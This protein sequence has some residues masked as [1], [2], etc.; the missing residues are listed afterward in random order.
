MSSSDFSIDC[1]CGAQLPVSAS[2]AGTTLECRCGRT[3]KVPL[4]SELRKLQGKGAYESGPIETILR[5]T[6]EGRL[7]SSDVCV[8]SGRPTNDI[9]RFHILCETTWF[10]KEGEGRADIILLFILR[11]FSRFLYH[12]AARNDPADLV[13]HGRNRGVDVVLRVDEEFHSQ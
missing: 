2:Q 10:K 3:V 11:V 9:C 13:V 1:E 5:L 8:I 6:K 7:P 12:L 4:L